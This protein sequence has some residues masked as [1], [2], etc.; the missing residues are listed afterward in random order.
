MSQIIQQLIQAELRDFI[1]VEH[2]SNI[3]TKNLDIP[4]E[5]RVKSLLALPYKLTALN[6]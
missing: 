6:P 2:R 5:F 1:S 3:T 4:S